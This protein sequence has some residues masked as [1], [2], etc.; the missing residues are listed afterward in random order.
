MS[1]TQCCPELL[2]KND[3]YDDGWEQVIALPDIT[4]TEAGPGDFLLLFCDG[5]VER[6]VF[7]NEQ[8]S[9]AYSR[10]IITLAAY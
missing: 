7:T 10:L 3:G 8:V 9:W 1:W 6:Q 2:L 5:I 4:Y